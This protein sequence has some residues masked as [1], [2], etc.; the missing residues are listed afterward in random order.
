MGVSSQNQGVFN[1]E[2]GGAGSLSVPPSQYLYWNMFFNYFKM[3]SE[4]NDM[5][6]IFLVYNCIEY[7]FGVI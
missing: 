3:I 2:R 5:V 7:F 1:K 6:I 4:N